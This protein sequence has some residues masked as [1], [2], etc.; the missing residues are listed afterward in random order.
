MI[1]ETANL[2][3]GLK[4]VKEAA[5]ATNTRRRSSKEREE[6][7][8]FFMFRWEQ[9]GSLGCL[10]RRRPEKQSRSNG[11]ELLEEIRPEGGAE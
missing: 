7:P 8:N 6:V 11:F 3:A 1:A 2:T 9:I 5:V 4:D 10:N